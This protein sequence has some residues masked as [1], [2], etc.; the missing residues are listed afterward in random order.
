MKRSLNVVAAL[1]VM[2]T[3]L[4][5]CNTNPDPSAMYPRVVELTFEQVQEII[6]NTPADLIERDYLVLYE[7]EP[8]AQIVE[9]LSE[10]HLQQHIMLCERWLFPYRNGSGVATMIQVNCQDVNNQGAFTSSPSGRASISVTVPSVSPASSYTAYGGGTDNIYAYSP[11]V[12]CPT[13]GS[14]Q[15]TSGGYLSGTYIFN[16]YSHS[17]NYNPSS[18]TNYCRNI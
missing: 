17:V 11:L 10:V 6:A 13:S 3:L 5:A 7:G 1:T 18:V 14:Y 16:G 15:A 9:A 2:S 4:P 12:Y 8:E